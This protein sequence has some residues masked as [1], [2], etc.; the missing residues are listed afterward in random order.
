MIRSQSAISALTVTELTIDRV[1][2]RNGMAKIEK[3]DFEGQKTFNAFVDMASGESNTS[4]LELFFDAAKEFS[5]G[6]RRGYTQ[7]VGGDMLLWDLTFNFTPRPDSETSYNRGF[8]NYEGKV[9]TANDSYALKNSWTMA[10]G[11]RD[12]LRE[13]SGVDPQMIGTYAKDLVVWY[14]DTHRAG[15]AAGNELEFDNNAALVPNVNEWSHSQLN[16]QGDADGYFLYLT[17]SN[18][19]P[20]TVPWTGVVMPIAWAQNRMTRPDSSPQDESNIDPDSPFPQTVSVRTETDE[21]VDIVKD[22]GDNPR[23][24]KAVAASMYCRE[25]LV[26]S[27]YLNQMIRQSAVRVIAPAGLVRIFLEGDFPTNLPPASPIET[28]WDKMNVRVTCNGVYRSVA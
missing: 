23:Y 26:G 1:N 16:A 21:Y 7:A 18:H 25:Q 15:S 3:L 14:S 17:G 5:G 10:H 13:I 9:Y 4:H 28:G 2:S 8:I 22:E 20:P 24:D 6:H 12:D 11:I 27:Y 19:T